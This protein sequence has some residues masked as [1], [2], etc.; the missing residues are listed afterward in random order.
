MALNENTIPV[1][2]QEL[3]S[4]AKAALDFGHVGLLERELR[5]A[6]E[7]MYVRG[8]NDGRTAEKL[9]AKCAALD[10]KRLH[11]GPKDADAKPDTR[12][13]KR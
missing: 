10:K 7:D 2:A 3:A 13:R 4:Y 12:G 11:T 8:V 1:R 6:L 5:K 9:A